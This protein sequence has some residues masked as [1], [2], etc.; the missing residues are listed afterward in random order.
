M[1]F[2]TK[3]HYA[4]VLYSQECF[5]QKVIIP[6]SFD[7]EGSLLTKDFLII[8]LFC[9][10]LIPKSHK[11]LFQKVIILKFAVLH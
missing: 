10:V 6:N 11:L 5:I 8:F 4:E 2:I 7:P 3:G 1:A 9:F